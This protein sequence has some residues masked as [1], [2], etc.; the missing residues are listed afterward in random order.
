MLLKLEELGTSKPIWLCGDLNNAESSSILTKLKSKF[1]IVSKTNGT[2]VINSTSTVIDYILVS[3]AYAS[4]RT[5]ASRVATESLDA[6]DHYPVEVEEDTSS[7][8]GVTLVATPKTPGWWTY[9]NGAT[10]KCRASEF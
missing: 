5:I 3:P 9:C 8:T 2:T 4:K 7:Q 1:T 10:V 6:S